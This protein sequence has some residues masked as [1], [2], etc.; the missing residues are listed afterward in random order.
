MVQEQES[1]IANSQLRLTLSAIQQVIGEKNYGEIIQ[2]FDTKPDLGTLPP[3]D[4][5]FMLPA[6]DYARLLEV[7]ESAYDD[8]GARILERIGRSCFHLLLREQQNWMSTARSTL[9]LWKP[10]RRIEIVLEAIIETQRK[11]YPQ[12]EAWIENRN[13]RIAYIEQSC[14]V[15][16]QRRSSTPVCFLQTGFIS[17]AIH[18]ATGVEFNCVEDACLAAGDPYCRFSIAKSKSSQK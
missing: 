13:G 6:Q 1:K 7:V 15:C 4:L 8:R 14:L 11:M 18:W 12:A 17:E 9:S 10:T 3:D 2:S 5:G 16:F